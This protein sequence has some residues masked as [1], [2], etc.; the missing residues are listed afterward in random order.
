MEGAVV[1]KDGSHSHQ[2]VTNVL[3]GCSEHHSSHR[4]VA[5]NSWRLPADLDE[6]DCAMVW[7]GSAG[8]AALQVLQLA[9]S[10][11]DWICCEPAS[12]NDRGDN[13]SLT[14]MEGLAVGTQ[15]LLKRRYFLVEK[16]KQANIVGILVSVMHKMPI[17]FNR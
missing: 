6:S 11:C 13:T 5:G 1:H 10:S 3:D 2:D 7:F 8:A 14:C 12:D 17:F 16:A 4:G 15:A 9:Y